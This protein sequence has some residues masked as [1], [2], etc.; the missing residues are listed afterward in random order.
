MVFIFRY[1][2]SVLRHNRYRII[3]PLL[4]LLLSLFA[5]SQQA[6][7]VTRYGTIA[8]TGTCNPLQRYVNTTN[9]DLYSCQVTAG[10]GA[11]VKVSGGSGGGFY[12]TIQNASGVDQLQRGKLQFTG[13]AVTSVAD[14]GANN[15]TVVTLTAGTGSGTPCTVTANSVQY[16]NAGAF[17]CISTMTTDGT[18]VTAQVGANWI[19]ADPASPT[20]KFHLNA[21]LITAGQNREI[22]VPDSDVYLCPNGSA[23]GQICIWDSATS[24]W[25]PGDPKVQGLTAHDAVGTS[26]N[27]VA[28][29]GYASATAPTDVSADGDIVRAWFF[30]NGAQATVLT[31]GSALIGGDA[32]NGL[33]VD[34]TRLPS[35]PAGTNVIGHVI[36]DT[37]STTAV[38]GN[39][40]VTKADGSDVTLGAKADAR[41]TATDVTAITIMQALKEISFMEQNP[42]SRAVTGAF[43]QATQPVSIADGSNTTLGAKAD[44]KS[45]ATDTTAVSAMA[46]LKEISAMEQ[47]PAARS[48]TQG[49]GSGSAANYWYTRETDGTN[50][51]IL[52]PC[53]TQA[54]I[55]K[56]ISQTANTQVVTGTAAKK[57]YICSINLV[58]AGANNVAIVEGTGTV[59]AT[60]IAGVSTGGTTAATGWNFAANMGIAQGNGM[61]SIMAEATNAD[62]LCILQSAAVQLSGVIG[63]VVQ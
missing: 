41:S 8:P 42:A 14:D 17:G 19:F 38:T 23:D 58:T 45:T 30:R 43:F 52:D 49:A 24:T 27:P 28:E 44:A 36:N 25:I 32:A 33:D 60:G 61:G 31:A 2:R 47:A 5:H 54:N 12:Q 9:G 18:I 51:V 4:V 21:S 16:N 35:L 48:V 26:T 57:I 50:P 29:G 3:V 13:T 10:V 20:K 6:N 63:Y 22:K 53:R 11:W 59:C 7:T 40:A 56:P 37:G 62:N 39:V 34:V 15:R 55:F 46:V 1:G